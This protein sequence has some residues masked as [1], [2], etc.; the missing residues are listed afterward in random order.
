MSGGKAGSPA[1][2]PRW[3]ANPAFPTLSFPDCSISCTLK[4]FLAE[5]TPKFDQL[6]VRKA[7]LPP[8]L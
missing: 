3:G 4:T 7:G 6:R 2:Q 8:L 1:G 5:I